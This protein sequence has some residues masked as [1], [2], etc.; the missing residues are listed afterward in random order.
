MK[1]QTKTLIIL[2]AVLVVL[3]AGFFAVK[4][5][6]KEPEA[7]P[8][9][10]E[11]YAA[12]FAADASEITEFSYTVDGEKLS[13]KNTADGWVSAEDPE[14]PLNTEKLASMVTALTEIRGYKQIDTQEDF[15][16]AEGSVEIGVRTADGAFFCT[17]GNVNSTIGKAYLMTDDGT[18]YTTDPAM[19]SEFTDPLGSLLLADAMPAIDAA[20]ITGITVKNGEEQFE[21]VKCDE[22]E[23]YYRFRYILENAQGKTPLDETA[24]NTYL[25][26]ATAPYLTCENYAP[27]AEELS[28][29]GFDD[30]AVLTIAYEEQ[31]D[32]E[33]AVTKTYQ[34]FFGKTYADEASDI[35]RR[36]VMLEDSEMLFYIVESAA[37]QLL[38]PVLSDL[39]PSYLAQMD[40][41]ELTKFSFDIEGNAHTMLMEKPADEKVYTLDGKELNYAF[42][43]SFFLDLTLMTSEGGYAEEL[44]AEAPAV[45]AEFTQQ[46]DNGVQ[47]YT[48][49]IY[50]YNEN[51]C[52]ADFSGRQ[53]KMLVS[54]RDY[55]RLLDSYAELQENA[56]R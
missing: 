48:L 38:S 35:D 7:A 49:N 51:F 53:D 18:I 12:L 1:K 40:F 25:T 6:T 20:S 30:P 10:A 14:M 41:S 28:A 43:E 29:A 26:S 31:T 13:F 36:Y 32:E 27:T 23:L 42:L 15:G 19:R 39:A 4:A 16:F 33:N 44:P 54:V 47:E 8:E 37:E 55:N 45:S 56:A 52:I 2:L 17:V 21:I 5:L 11:E 24:L 50:K 3:A 34:L 22:R 9:T 46:T